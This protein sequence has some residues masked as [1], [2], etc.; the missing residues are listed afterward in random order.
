MLHYAVPTHA[1]KVGW[2]PAQRL[3][4]PVLSA[5]AVSCTFPSTGHP[6]LR[7]PDML[8]LH[9]CISTLCRW[10]GSGAAA[11]GCC[12]CC[13]CAVSQPTLSSTCSTPATSRSVPANLL[14]TTWSPAWVCGGAPN[15]RDKSRHN[16][17]GCS[18]SHGDCHCVHAH[19]SSWRWCRFANWRSA[20]CTE[21]ICLQL[22]LCVIEKRSSS[23]TQVHV[24]RNTCP[25][26]VVVVL[27]LSCV[28]LQWSQCCSCF[29]AS[30]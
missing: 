5:T 27:L 6:L 16:V 12:G 22:A 17:G 11:P 15:K 20:A 19:C 14:Y 2:H 24:S 23:C 21:C 8:L 13:C 7:V 26:V 25:L 10:R 30:P 3:L 18:V 1:C 29:R 9:P 4:R 28:L